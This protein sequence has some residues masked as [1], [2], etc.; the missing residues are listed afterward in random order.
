MRAD[1]DYE[2]AFITRVGAVNG[3]ENVLKSAR[4]RALPQGVVRESRLFAVASDI[5]EDMV[6]ASISKLQFRHGWRVLRP[7]RAGFRGRSATPA[8]ER[9]LY[10]S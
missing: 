8:R 4:L 7:L 9:R 2:D 1:T 6:D 5:V 3:L 10:G